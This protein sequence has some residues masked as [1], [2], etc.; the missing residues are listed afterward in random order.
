MDI[1]TRKQAYDLGL[2]R[3]FTGVPCVQGHLAERRTG[4]GV[5][6]DC[7]RIRIKNHRKRWSMERRAAELADE[8]AQAEPVAQDAEAETEPAVSVK[9][10]R[11]SRQQSKLAA[12]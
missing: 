2:R 10:P 12:E 7:V 1:I 4:N 3:Y 5:C 8:A 9:Q 6:V 11:Q